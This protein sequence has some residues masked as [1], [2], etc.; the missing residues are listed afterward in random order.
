MLVIGQN[1]IG[2]DGNDQNPVVRYCGVRGM[3]PKYVK[4]HTLDNKGLYHKA[5]E[6]AKGSGSLASNIGTAY[7]RCCRRKEVH[8]H[9]KITYGK[10]SVCVRGI[11][12]TREAS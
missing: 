2:T 6:I 7:I 4:L 8:C 1:Q 10:T 12:H 11:S 9:P 5:I 3:K